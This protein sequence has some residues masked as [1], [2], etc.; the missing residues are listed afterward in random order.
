MRPVIVLGTDEQ[1]NETG[2]LYMC[3][4]DAAYALQRDV[5]TVHRALTGSRGVDN[6]AGRTV[7]DMATG[8]QDT[9]VK[10][11]MSSMYEIV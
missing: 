10:L 4:T 3:V 11:H 9:D 2:T 1:D 5:S 8:M 7:V 6:V